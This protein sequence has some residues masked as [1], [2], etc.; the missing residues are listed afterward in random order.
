MA[1]HFPNL[2][3]TIKPDPRSEK[4]PKQYKYEQNHIKAHHN[5]F[6]KSQQQRKNSKNSQ[7]DGK[8]DGM[9]LPKR[10]N[11]F[12]IPPTKYKQKPRT[13]YIKQI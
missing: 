12:P 10:W 13:L 4:N 3:K 6:A 11:S 5:Q 2:K 1:T 8:K 7:S 9:L